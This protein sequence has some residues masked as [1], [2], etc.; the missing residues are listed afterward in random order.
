M[1][2]QWHASGKHR[3]L[4]FFLMLSY[5]FFST[6]GSQLPMA[7]DVVWLSRR[8]QKIVLKLF[9]HAFKSAE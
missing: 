4:A 2:K 7:S 9:D 5:D 6:T 1:C 8:L 3:L